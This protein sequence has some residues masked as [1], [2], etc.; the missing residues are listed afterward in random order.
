[1]SGHGSREQDTSKCI[2]PSS[3]SAVFQSLPWG[4]DI[5]PFS[6]STMNHMLGHFTSSSHKACSFSKGCQSIFF[7]VHAIKP[8]GAPASKYKQLDKVHLGVWIVLF[9]FL[10]TLICSKY[11]DAFTKCKLAFIICGS[12]G[13]KKIQTQ[14]CSL[15][16]KLK[17][18]SAEPDQVSV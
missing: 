13:G 7:L 1:M 14:D 5:A 18:S 15:G 17:E 9:V 11:W 4:C 3:V 2:S 12:G 6:R 8:K 10:T 16:Y